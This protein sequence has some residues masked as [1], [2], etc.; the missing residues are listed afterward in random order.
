MFKPSL[1]KPCTNYSAY[2]FN[3]IFVDVLE[4]VKFLPT[5]LLL[6][7]YMFN[8]SAVN[9]SNETSIFIYSRRR[10]YQYNDDEFRFQF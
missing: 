6:T 3:L 10:I 7:K 1:I 8:N 5:L 9:V 4:C 2:F